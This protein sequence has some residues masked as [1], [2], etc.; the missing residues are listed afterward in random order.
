MNN[1]L[2]PT[3]INELRNNPSDYVKLDLI[4]KIARGYD[5]NN[6]SETEK[7]V[8]ND[9]LQLLAQD[10]SAR[11]RM[12]IS[13]KF[14]R[15]EEIS[16]DM[17]V[18]LASDIEDLVAVP[19]V[20]FSNLLTEEDL[21]G[22]ITSD[23]GARQRAV[24][25]RDELSSDIVDK[26]IT[27]GCQYTVEA[28]I[29]SNSGIITEEHSGKILDKYKT[30][31]AVIN[32]M[33]QNDKIQPEMAQNLLTYVS[34][35]LR[36]QIIK[37]YD[38]PHSVLENIVQTSTEKVSNSMV[39]KQLEQ[40]NTP[41]Q[42]ESLISKL[43]S[44]NNLN[45]NI[46]IKTLSQG[47]TDFFLQ[48]L[49]HIAD[50]PKQNAEILIEEEGNGGITRLFSKGHLPN[51]LATATKT[52]YR[53]V[54]KAIATDAPNISEATIENLRALAEKDGDKNLRYVLNVIKML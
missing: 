5:Q 53:V 31:E 30:S 8:A 15:N 4:G 51:Q 43:H 52:L 46:I 42:L 35:Q 22:I 17:V 37:K 54:Q 49:G 39:R 32:S 16:Y 11:I 24:A 1:F 19:I 25:R 33:F 26:L 41:E 27:F 23:T 7:K 36:G 21:T 38:I 10:I 44:Q 2:T 50:I 6:L 34:E 29:D 3:D 12:N 13:E 45:F 20:Q 47:H 9:I 40:I 28:L 14:C 48:S 18:N